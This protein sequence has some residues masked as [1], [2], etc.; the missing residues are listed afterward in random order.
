[1]KRN[2]EM[3]G[4]RNVSLIETAVGDSTG[5]ATLA[6]SDG[7]NLGMFTLGSAKGTA[8]YCVQL[9]RLDDLLEEIGIDTV[10]LIKMDIE[11]SEYR[12]LRGASRTLQRYKPTILI[13]LNEEALQGCESS[14]INVKGFLQDA[15]YRGWLIDRKVVRPLSE[16]QMVHDCDECLF[17]HRD[18]ESLMKRLGLPN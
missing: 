16:A 3:N 17:I 5:F 9:S 14:S 6:L 7:G 2:I 12:A 15:G 13:E 10:D 1:L 11:G 8:R 18:N 4:M